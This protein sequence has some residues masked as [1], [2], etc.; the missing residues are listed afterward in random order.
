MEFFSFLSRKPS[1]LG[2]QIASSG[3]IGL[4]RWE[5]ESQTFWF[6]DHALVLLKTKLLPKSKPSLL[7]IQK[8]LFTDDQ[9]KFAQ[10]FLDMP[11]SQAFEMVVRVQY[12]PD[13]YRWL[14]WRGSWQEKDDYQFLSGTLQDIHDERLT[15]LELEFTQEMLNEAQRIARLGSWQYDLVSKHLF[16]SEQTYQ[17]FG[18][19]ISLGAPQQKNQYR[20]FNA[21]D[22]VV[23]REKVKTSLRASHP[24][25]MDVRAI[26]DDGREITVRI[27]GRPLFDHTGNPYLLIGTVQDITDWVDLHQA[28][29]RT[30]QNQRAQ[31]QFLASV[32]HEIRTPMNAIFGMVQLLLRA[33]LPKRQAEQAK[34]VLSAATDL[35]AIINDLLDMAKLESGQMTLE[36]TDFDLAENLREVTVLHGGKIYSKN[37]EFVVEMD[38]ELP[39]MVSGDPLRLKQ[40][41]G[42]LLSNAAKFTKEGQIVLRVSVE[43]RV[44]QQVVLRFSVQD[45]GV[46]IPPHRL[47]AV[48]QKYVQAEVS[49]AREYGGTGLGLAICQELVQMMGGE[50]QVTSDGQHGTRFW[51]DV[52]FVP[53]QSDAE[54]PVDA[55]V[56]VLEPVEISAK[57]LETAL[58]QLGAKVQMVST[59]QQFISA[60]GSGSYSH[61]VISDNVKYDCSTMGASV[62]TLSL[63]SLPKLVLITLPI[64][65]TPSHDVFDAVILRPVFAHDLHRALTDGDDQTVLARQIPNAHQPRILVAEDNQTNQQSISDALEKLG[66]VPQRVSHGEAAVSAAAYRQFAAI[67]LDVQMPML[68]GMAATRQIRAAETKD[69][70]PPQCIIGLMASDNESQKAACLGAGMNDVLV[71]PVTRDMLRDMLQKHVSQPTKA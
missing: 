18:R 31:S 15:Q 2:A 43:G 38:S 37:L 1:Q 34:V 41:I 10:A 68:D 44:G 57:N 48:F 51:F 13:Y 6:S 40:V 52:P 53:V 58:H 56:L 33:D 46:G 17:I 47:A 42:N 65:H 7:Q 11:R 30:E 45:S 8:R 62:R 3:G 28:K 69:N 14:R 27:I 60:L 35:L 71:Q 63:A 23:L 50:I 21:D 4:W 24:Y 54:I 39:R 36:I 26:R 66:Y 49:T 67:L 61:V 9:D 55:H 25:E 16:W 32:S 64:S 19:D 70:K 12:A 5:P 20:Y 29:I 59:P 22:A